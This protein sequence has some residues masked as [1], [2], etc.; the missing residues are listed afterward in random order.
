MSEDEIWDEDRWESFLRENDKRVDRFMDLLFGFL[1]DFPPPED[2][3][4]EVGRRAWE[5]HLRDFLRGNGFSPEDHLFLLFPDDDGTPTDAPAGDE[6]GALDQVRDLPVY[7]RAFHLA[8]DVL[9][10]A[11][12]LPG[13]IKDSTLVQFCTHIT[14]IPANIAKGHGIGLERDMIGGNI[15][16]AK[17]GLTAANAALHLLHEMKRAS[18]MDPATYRSLYE[19]AFEVRNE[20]GLHIQA[21]RRRFDLGID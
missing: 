19:Q 15:A 11:N 14:Q 18:Y 1:A 17:R 8:T 16:C 2:D 20:L 12:A 13:D 4:D 21:L 10:W 3:H 9:D 7:Q 6:D 5:V